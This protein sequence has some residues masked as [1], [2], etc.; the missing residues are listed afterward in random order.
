MDWTAPNQL[1][2]QGRS[3]KAWFLR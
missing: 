1:H 2:S 3:N